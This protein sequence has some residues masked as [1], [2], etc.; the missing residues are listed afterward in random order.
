MAGFEEERSTVSP[1]GPRDL[2][3]QF[4]NLGP[5]GPAYEI[6]DIAAAGNVVIETINSE[7]HITEKLSTVLQGPTAT[8]IP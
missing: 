2:I 1:M 8:L 7:E 4:R 6:M 3:G 5:A